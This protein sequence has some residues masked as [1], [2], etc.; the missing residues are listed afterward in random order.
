MAS[1]GTNYA[2]EIS[3]NA[4]S[5]EVLPQ[6]IRSFNGGGE[7]N[8]FA[9]ESLGEVRITGI[10]SNSN[11]LYTAI[12]ESQSAS[13]ILSIGDQLF[14]SSWEVSKITKNSVTFSC[15]GSEK[16]VFMDGQN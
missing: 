15:N 12:V 7:N 3:P 8:P 6:N 11:G 13:Y 9:T 16:T 1:S 10:V 14:G 4:T 2:S 5:V